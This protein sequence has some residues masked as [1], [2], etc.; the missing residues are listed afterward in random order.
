MNSANLIRRPSVFESIANIAAINHYRGSHFYW[1]AGKLT[2]K[3]IL[4]DIESINATGR[5]TRGYC[6]SSGCHT[7]RKPNDNPRG[8]WKVLNLIAEIDGGL[9]RRE[10][11][12]RLNTKTLNLQL[13]A[14]EWAGLICLDREYT[15]KFKVTD[16]GKAYISAVL[17][18][19]NAI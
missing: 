8:Y 16:F 18:E 1:A 14:L 6:R 17:C 2:D 7:F 15:H 10:I 9:K 19:F 11:C 12:E 13:R 3:Q 5:N 4:D